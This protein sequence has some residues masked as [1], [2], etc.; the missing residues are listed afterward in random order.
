MLNPGRADRATG[1]FK[2]NVFKV[3]VILIVLV[4]ID[5]YMYGEHKKVFFKI[6]SGAIFATRKFLSKKITF[7]DF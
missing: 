1:T 5:S 2:Q 4:E 3:F 6:F 7:F